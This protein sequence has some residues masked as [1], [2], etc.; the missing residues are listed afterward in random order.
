MSKGARGGVVLALLVVVVGLV[1]WM[2]ATFA[3]S[4]PSSIDYTQG[5]QA[6]QPVN[7]T[8]QTVGSF[9]SGD[10]PTW[11]SYEAQAPNGQWVHSTN[12]Q[13]PANTRIDVTIQQY[14]SGSPLRNQQIGR[15]S[16]TVGGVMLLNGRPTS[17]VNSNVG[18]G[19]GHTFSVPALNISVPLVGINPNATNTCSVA[20]CST[21][22]VHNVIRFSF[23]T[24]K[25]AGNFRW[26]CFVPCALGYMFGNGGPM[27][28][29]GYMGGFLE[30]TN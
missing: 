15:I 7:L 24:P 6:G 26:Q 28:K 23:V 3:T 22:F 8:V 12:W 14:D 16:G 18:N 1:A 25:Q 11:V 19:V 30:V 10:H 13:L 9:G 17:L 20:P 2:F 4:M 21:S 27:S 5:H 29:V